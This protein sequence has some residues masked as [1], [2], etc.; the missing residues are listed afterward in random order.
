MSA[1]EGVALLLG[2]E[3]LP[4]MPQVTRTRP[5]SQK[6][7]G[8]ICSCRSLSAATLARHPCCGYPPKSH[9]QE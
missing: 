3:G 2:A 1:L 6:H 7:V 8:G 4:Y 9:Q 5:G